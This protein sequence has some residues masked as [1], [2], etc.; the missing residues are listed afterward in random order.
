M[1]RPCL[2]ARRPDRDRAAR[3]RSGAVRQELQEDAAGT[4]AMLRA[5][6]A[7]RE[8]LRHR[9]PHARRNLLRAQKVFVRGVFERRRPRARRAPDSGS[10]RRPDRWSSRDG[11]GRAVR[12]R[13]L[14]AAIAAATRSLS[15]RAQARTLPGVVKSTTSMRTGPSVCVCRMKRPSNL[16]DEPSSTASTMASPS[17]FATGSG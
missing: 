17:S 16:S 2:P 14:P 12:R 5:A 15:K 8:F 4:P 9:Q 6:A 3:A 7:A 13:R 10:C 11:H 1:R